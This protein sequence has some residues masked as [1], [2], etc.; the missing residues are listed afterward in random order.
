MGRYL[1]GNVDERIDIGTLA[2]NTLL[3]QD[4]GGTVIE[5]TLVS[6]IVA[7]WSLKD[8][9]P[10]AGQGP[11]LVGVAHSDYTAAEIEAYLE[12]SGSWTEGAK[13]QQEIA[14]RKIRIIGTL[15]G[16]AVLGQGDVLNDGKPIKTKLNWILVTGQTISVWAYNQGDA[17]YATTD[18]DLTVQGHANLFPT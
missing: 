11:L 1:K 4:M 16:G 6:S 3:K 10:A 13:I 14:K 9:T 15:K 8:F 5:R 17:A 12:T 2:A 7:T 18:P